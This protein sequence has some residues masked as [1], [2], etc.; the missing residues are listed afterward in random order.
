MLYYKASGSTLLVENC[1]MVAEDLSCVFEYSGP[2]EAA[3]LQTSVSSRMR[4]VIADGL[5]EAIS[6][7]CGPCVFFTTAPEDILM[8]TAAIDEADSAIMDG[9]APFYTRTEE[10]GALWLKYATLWRASDGSAEFAATL[11]LLNQYESA[12]NDGDTEALA[13]LLSPAFVHGF[14]EDGNISH[15][16]ETWV[17]LE[18]REHAQRTR[19][20]VS[21]CQSL[22]SGAQCVF[23][24]DGPVQQA[25]FRAPML[26]RHKIG[27]SDGLIVQ[28]EGVCTNCGPIVDTPNDKV[29]A[30]VRGIAPDDADLMGMLITGYLPNDEAP[31]LWLKYAPL[32]DEAGRP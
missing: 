6:A 8:W 20:T 15:D 11:K 12:F 29:I 25:L 7:Q 24:L 23:V 22:P 31:L 16:R 30:W 28:F 10:A 18:G 13:T 26:I 2:F 17:E 5:I 27:V 4:L 19:M 32:W 1:S 14:P 3:M 9:P 21:E